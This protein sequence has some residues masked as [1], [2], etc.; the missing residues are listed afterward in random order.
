M[1]RSLQGVVSRKSWIFET[2]CVYCDVGT[3]FWCT[4]CFRS[5]LPYRGGTFLK[6][7]YTFIT[8]YLLN[9]IHASKALPCL[10]RLVAALSSPIHW[11]DPGWCEICCGQ[12]ATGTGAFSEHFG[13]PLWQSFHQFSKVMFILIL[14]LSGGKRVKAGN[15]QIEECVGYHCTGTDEKIWDWGCL[16]TGEWGEEYLDLTESK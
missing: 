14:L 13:F 6:L 7:N 3:E 5:N 2:Q 16:I 12:S 4:G 8:L 11:L 9:W 1:H 10:W 15:L